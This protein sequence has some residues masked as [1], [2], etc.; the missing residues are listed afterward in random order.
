MVIAPDV[1]TCLPLDVPV[2]AR[3]SRTHISLCKYCAIRLPL[4]VSAESTTCF[5]LNNLG[6]N[7]P[8]YIAGVANPIFST[9]PEWWDVSCNIDNGT[10]QVNPQTVSGKP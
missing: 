6:T 8:G 7:R 1:L 4:C 10:I 9:K 3:V 5:Q 2:S